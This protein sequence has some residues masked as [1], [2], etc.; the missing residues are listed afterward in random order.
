MGGG[1][2]CKCGCGLRVTY[3]DSWRKGCQPLGTKLLDPSGRQARH[4]AIH[5]PIRDPIRN[6]IINPI[7]NA[8]KQERE[9][10]VAEERIANFP[11]CETVL[12][13]DGA[14]VN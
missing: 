7:N 8:K 13:L 10:L 5:D 2:K 11:N 6:P 4:N 14:A 3:K 1:N 9:R 12:T